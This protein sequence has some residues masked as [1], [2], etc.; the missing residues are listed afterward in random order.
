[1]QLH[2]LLLLE[3]RYSLWTDML[4]EA[5][6]QNGACNRQSTTDIE[7]PH[8]VGLFWGRYIDCHTTGS[9]YSHMDMYGMCRLSV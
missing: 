9:A 7:W 1:M 4:N 6:L 5:S 3:K 8:L 2:E